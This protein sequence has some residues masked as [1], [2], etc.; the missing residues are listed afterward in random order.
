MVCCFFL[1]VLKFRDI[2]DSDI[3]ANN[4]SCNT[5]LWKSKSL[6]PRSF[7]ATRIY[8]FFWR[9]LLSKTFVTKNDFSLRTSFSLWDAKL[10]RYGLH[11][12]LFFYFVV[13]KLYCSPRHDHFMGCWNYTEAGTRAFLPCPDIPGFAPDRKSVTSLSKNRTVI[14]SYLIVPH[15]LFYRLCNI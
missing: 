15:Y 9:L 8:L 1:P 7:E 14:Y 11:G 10:N 4:S 2:H 13:G 3:I 12:L 5:T 6:S